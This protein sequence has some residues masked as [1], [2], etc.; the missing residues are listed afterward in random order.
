MC[1]PPSFY[2]LKGAELPECKVK[3]AFK[4]E[5]EEQLNVNEGDY[6]VVIREDPTGGWW[7]EHLCCTV[8][9]G[10]MCRPC[11]AS[12]LLHNSQFCSEMLLC[13]T[14]GFSHMHDIRAYVRMVTR[15]PS[16]AVDGKP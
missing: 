14:Q 3:I 4:G 1:L 13:N 12:E 10:R 2:P 7:G 9:A 16:L 6:V 15:L 11:L 8:T 5:T